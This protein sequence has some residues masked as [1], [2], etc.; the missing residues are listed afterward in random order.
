MRTF[1]GRACCSAAGHGITAARHVSSRLTVSNWRTGLILVLRPNLA[2]LR[3]VAHRAMIKLHRLCAG[4]WRVFDVARLDTGET[5]MQ[6]ADLQ[7]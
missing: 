3:E 6:I 4:H 7:R 1:S 5:L 2:A